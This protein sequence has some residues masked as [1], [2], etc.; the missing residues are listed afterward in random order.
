MANKKQNAAKQ[1]PKAQPEKKAAAAVPAPAKQAGAAAPAKEASA[2]DSKK[3]GK[4]GGKN[5]TF[6][7]K[8]DSV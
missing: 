7:A 5:L 1:E 4:K 8:R 3:G 2:P 6:E